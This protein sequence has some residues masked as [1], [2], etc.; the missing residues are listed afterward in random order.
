M[1][2]VAAVL[3][4]LYAGLLLTRAT[5]IWGDT[6]STRLATV[7]VI[8]LPLAF[9]LWRGAGWAWWGTLVVLLLMLAWLAIFILMLS[10]TSEGRD[11]LKAVL[12]TPSLA[13]ASFVLEF[14]ILVLLLLPAGRATVHTGA[15]A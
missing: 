13:L 6:V 4:V 5:Q 9:G 12:T 11:V 7:G 15:A 3:L 8:S 14:V 1:T 10:V 2:R